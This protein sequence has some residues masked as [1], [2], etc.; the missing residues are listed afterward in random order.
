MKFNNWEIIPYFGVGPLQ[1]GL[2]RSQA[3]SF[4][5]AIPLT[6][7]QGPFAISDTDAYEELGL[8]LY[9]DSE[10]RLTCIM[11]FG[12]GPIHYKNLVLLNSCLQDIV[13]NLGRLGVT[14]RYDDGGYWFHDAGFVLYA[15]R[16]I[17]EAVTVF[18]SGYYE[19]QIELASN[20]KST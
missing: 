11:A 10:D 16:S 3:R 12:T 17:V 5:E 4:V 2:S 9:Y 13:E 18:R 8:H 1:F 15:P 19:E 6:F 20:V 14:S 7:R